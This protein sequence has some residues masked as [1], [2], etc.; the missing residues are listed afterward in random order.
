M[1]DF[2]NS[3]GTEQKHHGLVLEKAAR[4]SDMS[5][6]EVARKAGV[7]RRTLYNW[8]LQE[9]LSKTIV[10]KIGYI[11]NVDFSVDIPEYQM[12]KN[13]EQEVAPML[14]FTPLEDL[15]MKYIDLLEK[16]N[17]LLSQVN[18][19][20]QQS[21]DLV[22]NLPVFLMKAEEMRHSLRKSYNNK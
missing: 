20:Q 14:T 13:V 4:K 18:S 19:E 7:S 2:K 22:N 3:R 8:F 21:S 5:L 9:K 11:L 16:Y 12:F 17:S 6:S 15:K 10:V 1:E